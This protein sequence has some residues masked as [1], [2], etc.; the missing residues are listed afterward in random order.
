MSER[1][2]DKA[3]RA[4][5]VI[6]GLVWL[7]IGVYGVVVHDSLMGW[8]FAVGGAVLLAARVLMDGDSDE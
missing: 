1:T 3:Q 5:V 6:A 7:I 4:I 8:W 2:F